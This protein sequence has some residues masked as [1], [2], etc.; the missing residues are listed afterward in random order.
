MLKDTSGPPLVRVVGAAR[1]TPRRRE[2]PERWPADTDKRCPC[3][4]KSSAQSTVESSSNRSEKSG[5]T[6]TRAAARIPE[7]PL[8]LRPASPGPFPPD[9]DPYLPRFGDRRQL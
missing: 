9:P 6:T 2:T 1:P 3:C 4:A 7:S 8:F 5:Q